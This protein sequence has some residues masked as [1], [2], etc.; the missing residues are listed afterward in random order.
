MPVSNEKAKVRYH[1]DSEYRNRKKTAVLASQKKRKEKVNA[2]HRERT[3]IETPEQKLIK[4]G[5]IRKWEEENADK[6]REYRNKWQ[7]ENRRSSRLLVIEHYGGKCACCGESNEIFLAFDHVNG[8]GTQHIKELKG[9]NLTL[10]KW[11]IKNNFPEGIQILCHNCNYA[12][13]REGQCP[14]HENS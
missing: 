3:A 9:Q 5:K 8:G 1:E 14:H 4:R 10:V 12:K 7:R 13:H 11:I 6:V 2:Y